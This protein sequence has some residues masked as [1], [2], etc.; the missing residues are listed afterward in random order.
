MAFSASSS[1]LLLIV[2]MH[3]YLLNFGIGLDQVLT[4]WLPLEAAAFLVLFATISSDQNWV[5]VLILVFAA[6]LHIVLPLRIGPNY[7]AGE[8]ATFG[9]Q[10]VTQIMSSGQWTTGVGTGSANIVYSYFPMMFVFTA[11]WAGI[12]SIP[13][14]IITNYAFPA[15]NLT[16]LLSVRMLTRSFGLSKK[17]A[18]IVLFLY[19]LTPTIHQIESV[20]HYEAYAVIFFPIALLYTMKPRISMAE[21]TIALFSILA[22]AFSHFFTALDLALYCTVLA[23]TYLILRG[24][25]VNLD[26]AFLS[27]VIPLAWNAAVASSYFQRQV[28]ST[29][30]VLRHSR[31]ILTLLNRVSPGATQLGANFYAAPWLA[32]TATA[33]NLIIVVFSLVAIFTL[34]FGLSQSGI[35]IKRKDALTYMAVIWVFALAFNGTAYFGVNWAQTSLG[36]GPS[37]A[38]RITVFSFIPFA[39]FCGLGL[40]LVLNRLELRIHGDK[41][42]LVK[43]VLCIVLIVIFTT[44]AVV[45]AYSRGFYDSTYHQVYYDEYITWQQSSFLEPIYLG[46][47]WSAA[48][49]HTL[50]SN[51]PMAGSNGLRYFVEAYG[52]QGW[53]VDNVSSPYVAENSRLSSSFT[54]YYAFDTL[55]VQLP[56]HLYNTT[57]S[58]QFISSN[59]TKL[60]TIFNTG[61]LIVDFKPP[62]TF[63]A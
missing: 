61:R 50:A 42:L 1:V 17:E 25:R 6:T 12:G 62:Q 20:F 55:N 37:A 58:P 33:R 40:Y 7:P 59:D 16:A 8:D 53:W 9:Y 30:D 13:A 51:D 57:L 24:T 46:T 27:V 10:A 41:M 60:N 19:S 32:Q 38:A 44:S 31:D 15:V 47:W 34:C 11:L 43:A 39:I 48:N 21:R 52:Y 36:L 49:N 29:L 23:A 45:Q 63:Q 18:N 56:D 35:R 5:L 4:F 3:V 54:V 14:T 2:V 22:V 28:L 26:L